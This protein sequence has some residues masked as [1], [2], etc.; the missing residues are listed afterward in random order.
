MFLD[1]Q[2]KLDSVGQVFVEDPRLGPAAGQASTQAMMGDIV[3]TSQNR[4]TFSVEA[5]GSAPIER[6]EIRNGRKILETYRP[7]TRRELGR[8]IRILWEG[9][10]CRGRARQTTWDGSARIRGNTFERISAINFFNPDKPLRLVSSTEVSWESITTGGFAGFDAWLGEADGGTIAID[11]YLVRC[12]LAIDSIGMEDICFDA[13]GLGR[14]MRVFR[15]PDE[16]EHCRISCNRSTELQP[17]TDN[18]LYVC[19]TQ[20]DGH[21]AWSSP[22][23]LI[24]SRPPGKDNLAADSL[25][26]R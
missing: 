17:G 18:P 4:V 6:L 9:A 3:R 19:L 2:I 25:K 8:R 16:N 22:I 23:Y 13:G 10:E 12:E 15:L 11:T 26:D 1:T 14:G 20:E 7:Y 24:P 21:R 5:V